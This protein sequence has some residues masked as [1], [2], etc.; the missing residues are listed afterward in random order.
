VHPVSPRI[1]LSKRKKVLI[2]KNCLVKC[3]IKNKSTNKAEKKG[4][5]AAD[6]RR[7]VIENLH[8]S[9][10]NKPLE[11]VVA[12]GTVTARAASIYPKLVVANRTEAVTHARQLRLLP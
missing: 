1:L 2:V 12:T 9:D 8:H 4:R 5:S 3:T 7:L 10:L 11:R 6:R